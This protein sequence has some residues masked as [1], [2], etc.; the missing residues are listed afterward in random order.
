MFHVPDFGLPFGMRI[1]PECGEEHERSHAY[2]HI[3]HAFKMRVHNYLHGVSESQRLKG[4][5]RAY[6]RVYKRRGY[7][8]AGPCEDCGSTDDIEMHHDD[9]DRPLDVTWLC[10]ACHLARDGKQLAPARPLL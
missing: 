6:A 7:L 10:T 4:I 3:C 2:C 5:T 1:C 8:I 9:Y